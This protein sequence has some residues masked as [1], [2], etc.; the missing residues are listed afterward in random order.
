VTPTHETAGLPHYPALD[1]FAPA[2]TLVVAGFYGRV[3]SMSGRACSLGGKP[4]GSYGRSVY[5]YNAVR[6]VDRYLTHLDELYLEV[7]TLVWPGRRIG[8]ICDAALAGKPG[9]SHVHYGTNR[10]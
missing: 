3:R 6:R 8:T 2:G 1:L 5:V 9:T 4:G 7:G 10:S